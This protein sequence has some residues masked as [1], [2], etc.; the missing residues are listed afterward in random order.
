MSRDLAGTIEGDAV[1]IRSNYGESHGD[2]LTYSFSGQ[3]SGDRMEGT[4]EMG[5]YLGARWT[6]RRHGTR[7]A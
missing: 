4:L 2:A 5:E 1:K 3:T 6:A 7:E